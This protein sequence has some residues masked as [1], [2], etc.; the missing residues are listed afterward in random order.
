MEALNGKVDEN[1]KRI[2]YGFFNGT[3][4]LICEAI[5]NPMPNISWYHNGRRISHHNA[6]SVNGTSILTV[7][8]NFSK[9]LPSL[10]NF[11]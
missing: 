11:K 9:N 8:Y 7:N 1:G 5:G 2:K 10:A 3:I 4:D 6:E